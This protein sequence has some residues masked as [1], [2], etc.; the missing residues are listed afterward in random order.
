MT[1]QSLPLTLSESLP[2]KTKRIFLRADKTVP[3][4]EMMQVM[5]VLATAGYTRVALVGLEMVGEQPAL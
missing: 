5:N 2:D 1:Q 3:Y 4:G